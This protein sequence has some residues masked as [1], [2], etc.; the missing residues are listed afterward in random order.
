M[1]ARGMLE[2]LDH[3]QFGRIVIPDSP[4][5]IHGADR[6]PAAV[7]SRLGANTDEVLSSML[8]LSAPEIA[9]LRTEGVIGPAG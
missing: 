4:I 9:V 3:P 1:H 8:N 5:R 6:L 2:W 7:S